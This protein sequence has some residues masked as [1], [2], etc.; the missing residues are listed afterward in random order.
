MELK[1]LASP[2]V[3]KIWK[4][5]SLYF[6]YVRGALRRALWG[7]HPVK[8]EYIKSKRIKIPNPSKR[9]G[10][11]A[12]VWGAKC[13]KCGQLYV[14]KKI[15]VDHITPAGSLLCINDIT[16]FILGLS[17]INF[18]SLQLLCNGDGTNKCHDIKTHADRHNISFEQAERE[19]EVIAFKKLPAKKQKQ[20]LKRLGYD[21]KLMG[22]EDKRILLFRKHYNI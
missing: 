16:P 10:A 5:D 20:K 2:E 12:E 3:R 9:K 1:K 11:R 18:D 13:E 8:F 6:N 4:T 21:E 14:M 15:Q 17:L 19:K 22:N 7:K